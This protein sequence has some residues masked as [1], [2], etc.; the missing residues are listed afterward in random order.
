M[1]VILI[2]LILI[3][4]IQMSLIVVLFNKKSTENE[5]VE[6]RSGGIYNRQDGVTFRIPKNS[7]P[8]TAHANISINNIYQA[9]DLD[10][11]TYVLIKI[12]DKIDSLISVDLHCETKTNGDYK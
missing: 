2:A 9:I 12:P 1:R 10:F 11:E 6:F 3:C 7:I 8:K 5:L 4:I